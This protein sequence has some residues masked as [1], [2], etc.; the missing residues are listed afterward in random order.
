MTD[1][2]YT[3]DDAVLAELAIRYFDGV[4][5]AVLY[6]LR[7]E[8]VTGQVLFVDGGRHLRGNMYGT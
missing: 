5:D 7:A 2:N 4:A 6:L 3:D 8:F 1:A